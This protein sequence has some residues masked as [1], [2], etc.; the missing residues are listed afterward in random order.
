MADTSPAGTKDDFQ[1]IHSVSPAIAGTLRSSLDLL[2][3]P[4]PFSQVGLLTVDEFLKAAQQ[5]RIKMWAGWDLDR[6]G[7]EDLHRHGVVVP[8][9][10]VRLTEGDPAQRLETSASLTRQH[11]HWTII[12][13]LYA[14][15]D[16]GRATDP[17]SELFEP[18]PSEQVRMLWPSTERGYLYS[19]HQLLG[20]ERARSIVGSLRPEHTERS[21]IWRLRVNDLPDDETM[22]AIASW[23]SL[24]I[25]LSAVDTRAWP[26]ITHVIHHNDEA[27][28]ASNLAQ[29]AAALLEWLGLTVDQLRQQSFNLRLAANFDDV[30]GDFYDL[31]RRSNASAW[32]GLRGD[33][34]TAMDSRMAAEVLDRFA[35]ESDADQSSAEP[36]EHLSMQRLSVRT[37][38]LDAVLTHL[39]L[40]PHP[41]L[42]VALEG[43]TEML[44]VPRVMELLG[45]R[46]DADWIRFVDFGGTTKSLALLA[47]YAAEPVVGDDHGDFVVLDRPVTRFLVLT[48]AENLYRTAAD[49][50]HQ[51][52]LL[53]DSIAATLPKDLRPDLYTRGARIVEIMTWGKYPFEFAHFAD[54]RLADALLARSANNHPGGRPGL[55]RSIH[56]QRTVDPTPDIQDAWKGSGVSKPDLADELWPLLE[57]RIQRAI[58]RG[59]QGPPIMKGLVRA[60]EL[61]MLSYRQTMSLRRKPPSPRKAR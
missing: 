7:L 49:R 58:Q 60:Y 40:S 43:A 27:W 28:R 21:R 34:R 29:D 53:L 6:S 4:F 20:L 44:L 3:L 39:H 54:G 31:V 2:T 13:E 42:V 36:R 25:T 9:F 10:C 51:R 17:A 35:D 50:R 41:P 32:D 23:R 59:T 15:A 33:A 5:R 14:A 48:D 18:W 38:S 46:R 8:L 24:A 22:H 57:A 11:V 55:V 37:R 45:M 56:L 30:L 26:Y 1:I 61:A 52:R 12:S 47:R 19:P 16:E